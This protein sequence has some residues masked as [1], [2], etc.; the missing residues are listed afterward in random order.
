M[1]EANQQTLSSGD[2]EENC[3]FSREYPTLFAFLTVSRMNGKNRLTG[4]IL[5]F[6]EDGKAKLWVNDRDRKR[7]SFVTGE[8]Y[9]EV[10]RAC[11][12]GIA[13]GTLSWRAKKGSYDGPWQGNN[14]RS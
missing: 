8:T 5:V 4:T 2:P 13:Q 6:W 3:E 7:V 14:K 10:L 11:D 9:A 12:E 1:Y